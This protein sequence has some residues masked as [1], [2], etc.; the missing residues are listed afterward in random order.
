MDHRR[1]SAESGR[2]GSVDRA[3][4]RVVLKVTPHKISSWDHAKLGGRY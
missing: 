4:K 1:T 3:P 2:R